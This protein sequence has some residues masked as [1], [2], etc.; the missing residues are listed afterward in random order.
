MIQKD[1]SRNA[2]ME[3]TFYNKNALEAEK[4]QMLTT[5]RRGNNLC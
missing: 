3:N 5:W 4:S 1:A 2:L